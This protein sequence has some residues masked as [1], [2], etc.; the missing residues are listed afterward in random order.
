MQC[1]HKNLASE[2]EAHRVK[3]R[4]SLSIILDISATID[5]ISTPDQRILYIYILLSYADLN[6][7][8][9]LFGI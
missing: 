8:P 6:Y 9:T 5:F 3:E 1:E 7:H 4:G 2:S